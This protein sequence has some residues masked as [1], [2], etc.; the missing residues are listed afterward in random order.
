VRALYYAN[1]R[2]QCGREIEQF[3][4]CALHRTITITWRCRA[5]RLAMNSCMVAHATAAEEDRAREEWLRGREARQRERARESARV[6]ERRREVIELIRRQEEKEKE[7]ERDRERD[8]GAE[9]EKKGGV[10]G[11]GGGAAADAGGGIGGGGGGFWGS[12]RR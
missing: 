11:G 1:V 3:A 7:R 12:V 9:R 10:G 6:E 5:Q 4:A 2:A 8:R